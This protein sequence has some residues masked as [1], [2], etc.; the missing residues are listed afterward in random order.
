[1]ARLAASFEAGSPPLPLLKQYL[2]AAYAAARRAEQ[3]LTAQHLV[4]HHIG[5]VLAEYSAACNS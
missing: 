4:M 1:M 5:Q 3:P 2:P